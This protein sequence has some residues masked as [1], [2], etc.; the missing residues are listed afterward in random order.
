MTHPLVIVYPPDG[1]GARRVRVNGLLMGGARRLDDVA[2]FIVRAGLDPGTI[3]LVDSAFVE[4]RGGGVD[5]WPADISGAPA[6][7]A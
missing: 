2:A 1:Q 3:G 7:E 5:E 6:S 4:W